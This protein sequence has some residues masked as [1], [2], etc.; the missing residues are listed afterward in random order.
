MPNKQTV[1][2][3]CWIFTVLN[4]LYCDVL[5][6][7]DAHLL[8][9]YFEGNVGGMAITQ[10]FLL[11]ASVLM[12]ISISMV[13]LSRILPY[14]SN[15]IASIAAGF[16]TTAVQALTLFMGRPANYYLFFSVIEIS[17]TT[18]ILLSAWRWRQ[19]TETVYETTA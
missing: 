19:T 16:I 14:K 12:E 17:T 15:R 6:L 2:S 8:R 7:M 1:L 10:E 13:L 11:G 5:S 18:F 3:T 9:Q 4:Y